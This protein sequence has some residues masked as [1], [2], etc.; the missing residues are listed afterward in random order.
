MFSS[1]GVLKYFIIDESNYKLTLLVDTE[2][3]RYYRNFVPKSQKCRPG[4]YAPHITV[5]RNER[6][7]NM[8]KWGLYENK[9][10]SFEYEPYIWYDET[11]WWLNCH[12]SFLK[13]QEK[14]LDYQNGQSGTCLQVEKLVFI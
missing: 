10:I 6:P 3:A 4:R 12:S 13:K 5:V 8:K 2:I 11:Y 1:E 7:L 14:N 9:V